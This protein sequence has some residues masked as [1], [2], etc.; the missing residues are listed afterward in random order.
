RYQREDLC[1]EALR[2]ARGLADHPLLGDGEA[3]ALVGLMLLQSARLATRLPADGRPLLLHEQD[4]SQ[5]DAGRIALAHR[6]LER[7][8]RAA[9]LSSLHLQAAIAAE[10]AT[11]TSLATT[12]WPRILGWYELLLQMDPSPPVRLGHAIAIAEVRGAAAGLGLLDAMLAERGV[13]ASRQVAP[14]LQAARAE[15]LARLGRVEAACVACDAALAAARS[16]AERDLLQRRRAALVIS[17][18]DRDEG[19]DAR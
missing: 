10:H 8:Q 1:E 12:R 4:R 11:A 19:H 7:A 14:F 3:D 17:R 16:D 6:Y 13:A 5:W 18:T 2:L 9:Q 15:L